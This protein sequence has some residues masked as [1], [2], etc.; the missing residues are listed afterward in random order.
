MR[1]FYDPTSTTSRAVT[2]FAAEASIALDLVYVGLQQGEHHAQDFA[3]LNPNRQVPVLEDDGF[4]LTESAAILR[5]LADRAGSPL[6]PREPRARALVDSRLD[7]FNTGFARDAA[8]GLVYPQVLPGLAIAND[9]AAMQLEMRARQATERWLAVLDSHWI[10]DR[11]FVAGKT[12]TIADFLGA[13]YV[14]LL[15]VVDFDLRPYA[16]VNR[17]QNAMRRLPH[18]NQSYAAFEGLLAAL[19]PPPAVAG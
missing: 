11:G 1:L 7:W 14:T 6:Y 2:L 16:N 3:A 18:W 13:A 8:Y 17:W 9:E 15:A 19:R 12:L 4:V 5:Y 10:A